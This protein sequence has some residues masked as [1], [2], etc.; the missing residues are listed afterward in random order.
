MTKHNHYFIDVS[1]LQKMDVYRV[2]ERFNV[3]CPVLQH[4]SKKALCAGN[5][6]HK[7]LRKDIQDMI[8]SLNRK[9]EMMEEDANDN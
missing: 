1:R 2:L 8:D 9:L 4:V 5:R 3:T 6:G 7:D